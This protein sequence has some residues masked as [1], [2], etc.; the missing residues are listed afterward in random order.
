VSLGIGPELV[1][2]VLREA[3]DTNYR[4]A[5]LSRQYIE[6]VLVPYWEVGP[7]GIWIGGLGCGASIANWTLSPSGAIVGP[8][9]KPVNPD[10]GGFVRTLGISTED[11]NSNLG[12]VA[13]I[14]E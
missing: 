11:S 1:A 6:V 9:F 14:L 5:V 8:A 7:V 10:S 4:L 3:V 12:L 13:N 2:Y